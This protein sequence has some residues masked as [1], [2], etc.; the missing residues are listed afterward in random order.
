MA[1]YTEYRR[2]REQIEGDIDGEQVGQLIVRLRKNGR[3]QD[4]DL[5]TSLVEAMERG[6]KIGSLARSTR[7]KHYRRAEAAEGRAGHLELRLAQIGRV[8]NDGL[9]MED[10]AL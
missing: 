4:A 10:P 5:V 6:I 8:V 3:H 1:K 9:I 7:N 2:V